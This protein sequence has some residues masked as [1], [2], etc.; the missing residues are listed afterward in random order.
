MKFSVLINN[1]NYARYVGEAVESVLA[2]TCPPVE[3]IVV[4]DG[5]TDDSLQVLEKNFGA[6]PRVRVIANVNRGQTAAIAAG[7]DVAQGE[8]LCLLDA[9]DRYKPD[10]LATL[11]AHYTSHLTTDLT[12][13]RY[14]PLGPS[15]QVGN[16]SI[17]LQPGRDYDY[18]HTALLTC[19]SKHDWIGN[20]TSTISLRIRLARSLDLQDVARRFYRSNQADFSILVGASLLGARKYYVHRELTEYRRHVGN[21]MRRYANNESARYARRFND[22]IILNYFK[23]RASIGAPLGA[24]LAEELRTIPDPLP[25]HLQAYRTIESKI[26]SEQPLGQRIYQRLRA[27]ERSLRRVRKKVVG[28][29]LVL[30][31]N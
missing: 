14:E 6:N 7:V 30:P 27:A 13:C 3:I 10:Y 26:A 31:E 19:F 20:F 8:I 17:W 18:G 11:E 29:G 15:S 24:K 25:E 16:N 2:Q 5:S 28:R 9:D 1:H 21:H 4:D 22:L 12:F 23:T